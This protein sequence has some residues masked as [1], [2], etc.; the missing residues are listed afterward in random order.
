MYGQGPGIR[1]PLT[2]SLQ[3]PPQSPHRQSVPSTVLSCSLLILPSRS[4][5]HLY[6]VVGHVQQLRSGRGVP[7]VEAHAWS[8]ATSL[9]AVLIA[10]Q[11]C[12][13]RAWRNAPRHQGT[14]RSRRT[15]SPTSMDNVSGSAASWLWLRQGAIKAGV[16]GKHDD[17]CL[18]GGLPVGRPQQDCRECRQ[19]CDILCRCHFCLNWFASRS[20][21]PRAPDVQVGQGGQHPQL[22]RQRGN[23]IAAQI[24]FVHFCHLRIARGQARRWSIRLQVGMCSSWRNH[25]PLV[26]LSDRCFSRLCTLPHAHSTESAHTYVRCLTSHHLASCPGSC[27]SK[28]YTADGTCVTGARKLQVWQLRRRP[29]QFDCSTR[30]AMPSQAAS[31]R[32]CTKPHPQYCT[33]SMPASGMLIPTWVRPRPVS[34]NVPEDLADTMALSV[35]AQRQGRGRRSSPE[36]PRQ[37]IGFQSPPCFP[38][39]RNMSA[40]PIQSLHALTDLSTCVPPCSPGALAGRAC[41]YTNTR[42]RFN[43]EA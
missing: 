23:G 4:I 34:V 13:R 41:S 39:V 16:R 8:S 20:H 24:N 15:L 6:P 7:G 14:S 25:A 18:A 32:L 33:A 40:T 5:P 37:W 9:A 30:N 12:R 28:L 29:G 42:L 35:A 26:Q 36:V 31:A 38:L 27:S 2:P 1:Q 43:S 17:G 3:R 21:R 19:L 11:T 10:N 22:R